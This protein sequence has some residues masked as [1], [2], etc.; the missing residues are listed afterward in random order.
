MLNHRTPCRHRDRELRDQRPASHSSERGTTASAPCTHRV[1]GIGSPKIETRLRLS[2]HP[3][4]LTGK[5]SNLRAADGARP[6]AA[7]TAAG[8]GTRS[9]TYGIIEKRSQATPYLH[10]QRRPSVCRSARSFDSSRGICQVHCQPPQNPPLTGCIARTPIRGLARLRRPAYEPQQ[11][12][13]PVGALIP[14]WAHPNPTLCGSAPLP[15]PEGSAP[16]A[17]STMLLGLSTCAAATKLLGSVA[18]C[19]SSGRALMG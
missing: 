11:L 4:G 13:Q 10:Q 12:R 2:T 7:A 6:G 9:S 8:G 18:N 3:L 14:A 1:V 16:S 19:D 5:Q 15:Q 17:E